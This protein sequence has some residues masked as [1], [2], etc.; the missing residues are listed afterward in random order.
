[1]S[2]TSRCSVFFASAVRHRGRYYFETGRVAVVENSP[3]KLE[4][5]VRGSGGQ[6]YNVTLRTDGDSRQ[7]LRASCSCPH[8][9]DG[10]NCKHLW[11]T[12]LATNL[13]ALGERMLGG[14]SLKLIAERSRHNNNEVELSRTGAATT[15]SAKPLKAAPSSNSA[16]ARRAKAKDKNLSNWR[17]PL[18]QAATAATVLHLPDYGSA[19]PS[20]AQR[21]RTKRNWFVVNVSASLSSGKLWVEIYQQETK[22]NGEFGKAKRATPTRGADADYEDP[23]DAELIE[24]LLGNESDYSSSYSYYSYYSYGQQQRHFCI[25]PAFYSLLLPRMCATGRF[26]WA[27]DPAMLEFDQVT[28]RLAWDDSEPWRLR[29]QMQDDPQRG[30]WSL[31]GELHRGETAINLNQP[32]LLLANG[33]MLLPDRIARL[34]VGNSFGWISAL[35]KGQTLT[36]PYHERADFMSEIWSVAGVPPIQFPENFQVEQIRVEPQPKLIVKR[37]GTMPNK[38]VLVAEAAFVYG[39]GDQAAQVRAF[40][41][42]TAIVDANGQRVLLR[43]REHEQ[44]RLEQL[45]QVGPQPLPPFQRHTGD[46]SL[47]ASQ[48]PKIVQ[49]L[50]EQGWLVES[51]GKLIRRASSFNLS[52]S[53]SVDWF[54]L[55][56]RADFDGSSV[57]L[58]TLLR[59][60]RNNDRLVRLDDGTQGILPEEWLKKFGGLAQLGE[61]AGDK[62]KFAPSQA[63]LLD[64]MLA[65]QGEVDFDAQFDE[66]RRKLRSFSTIEARH[67]PETFQGELRAY[68]RDGLGWLHFLQEFRLGGCLAD[69]MGL[70]KTVQ[71]LALLEQRRLAQQAAAE[72][73]R[74]SIVVVPKSLIFNWLDEAAKFTP[75]LKLVDYTGLTRANTLANTDEFDVL[76]TT[77]GTMRRDIAQLKEMAF[78][79]A[80]LDE[81]QAIKN[82]DS[83]SSKAVRLLNARH[84]LAM[85]GTPVENHLGELWSLF[86][87]LNPGMLGQSSV[88]STIGRRGGVGLDNE[89]GEERAAL[90]MLA[91][92]LRPFML[93]RT[94]EQVLTELPE[95]TEQ[96]L[97]CE[98]P[99]KQQK[100]YDELRE[101]YRASLTQKVT[102]H[103]LERSKIHVLEALLR[104]R[105]AACHPGLI[106]TKRS[107]E[108]SA[109]LALLFEQI[110]EIVAEGH[111]ALI[112][113][114]FTSLLSIVRQHFDKEGVRY[115]YLDGKT[116]KRAD[117]V[118]A[119][120][121]DSDCSLFLIS[122]KAG[123]HGLNLTAADYVFILDPWWNPAV[124]AQAVDRAHRI[125]Q[126]RRVFAYRI[127]CRNTVEEKILEMQRNK[128]DLA[129]AIIS[130][131][132]SILRNLTAADLQLLLS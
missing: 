36:I 114:Q 83:Q 71:V 61:A 86:E 33:L 73:R 122:L 67:E 76:L 124:E 65:E 113:S 121:S 77:Y 108:P 41:T 91:K 84:R 104:L 131:D 48:L 70:G 16:N 56:G 97:F 1:M 90:Q 111:K 14:G 95:K 82:A 110:E 96:T 5:V 26:V 13:T 12:L 78:D 51:E 92:G 120:Q 8:F 87:F 102:E 34:D 23:A 74:P 55:D 101:Y 35:R 119:F 69:D 11:A 54:E 20:E 109:K 59:A 30:V 15:L 4:A 38:S 118:K 6:K 132:N 79:Y 52:V 17:V 31:K 50:S 39:T 64:A 53:S 63:L 98:M 47:V 85:T 125:G 19:W 18:R 43:D 42:R 28:Q 72:P 130:E 24:W 80:I 123:G 115:E 99:P 3:E 81:S 106:D 9:S 88:F 100:L 27:I 107:G 22:K 46:F 94:K 127:I 116:R 103:G 68:Q 128:R 126:S 45:Q 62:L 75:Q 117:R 105:Q 40:E 21:R 93:R 25:S 37:P 60:L 44:R 129:E 89:D 49:K 10:Q 66:F 57:S 29:L 32:V 112:F 7:Q 2:L 58:P